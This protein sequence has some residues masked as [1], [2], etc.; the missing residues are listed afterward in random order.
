MVCLVSNSRDLERTMYLP[1][2][3]FYD[4]G[5]GNPVIFFK[6]HKLERNNTKLTKLN[7][8]ICDVVSLR[9]VSIMQKIRKRFW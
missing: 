7:F 4:L 9:K 6:L 3:S 1:S 5:Q 2:N 8:N